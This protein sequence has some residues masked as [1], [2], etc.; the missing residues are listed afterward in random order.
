MKAGFL[1]RL[2]CTVLTAVLVIGLVST[3]AMAYG[4]FATTSVWQY[5]TVACSNNHVLAIKTD[6]SLWA[7]GSNHRGQLGDGTT[8][9]RNVPV[10]IMDNVIAVSTD[11]VAS[12]AITSDGSLWVWGS[13]ETLNNIVTSGS[14]FDTSHL[15]NKVGLYPDVLKP[16]RIMTNIQDVSMGGHGG[17]LIVVARKDG[18]VYTYSPNRN[19]QG[20]GVTEYTGDVPGGKTLISNVVAVNTS[21][22]GAMAIKNDGSLW[23][24][25]GIDGHY[26]LDNM[27][28]GYVQTTESRY[29]FDKDSPFGWVYTPTK[30]MDDVVACN[31]GMS[32][33]HALKTDGTLLTWGYMRVPTGAVEVVNQPKSM[34]NVKSSSGDLVVKQDGTLWAIGPCDYGQLANGTIEGDGSDKSYYT[35]AQGQLTLYND[36]ISTYTQIMKGVEAVCTTG[37]TTFVLK[38]DGSLWAC[39]QAEDGIIGNGTNGSSI[40]GH[41]GDTPIQVKPIKILDNVMLPSNNPKKYTVSAVPTP[42]AIRVD[43]QSVS[44]DAYNINSNNYC[45]IRD[46]AQLLN[47][48]GKQFNV[49][50]DNDLK[51]VSMTSNQAYVPVGGELDKDI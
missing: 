29:S 33:I 24:W 13:Y 10:K 48:T 45:K 30:V 42:S 4:A 15:V 40:G 35:N 11:N 6:G 44:L 26:V 49:I 2:V 7:W 20:V 50:W 47:G 25:G 51:A 14:E 46:V 39:G 21:S 9:N 16:T 38:T 3:Q 22:D 18:S 31:F 19:L 17:G 5:Q 32:T 43:G 1:K 28:S 34:E 37:E 8:E 27:K 12:A 41:F 36:L 23:Y